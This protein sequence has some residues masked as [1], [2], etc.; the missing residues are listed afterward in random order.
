MGMELSASGSACNFDI[1][2]PQKASAKVDVVATKERTPTDMVMAVKTRNGRCMRGFG[3]MFATLTT[4]V[5]VPRQQSP[6][7]TCGAI[8]QAC[9]QQP[10]FPALQNMKDQYFILWVRSKRIK[11]WFPL[12]I[13]SGTEAAKTLKSVKENAVAKAIGGDKL[14]DFQIVKALGMSVYKQADEVKKQA[15][16]MHPK[17]NYARELQYGFKEIM[18]NT[19]FNDNP[20]PFMKIANISVI[21]PE[22]ELRNILDDAGDYA[23]EAGDKLSTVGDNVK[24]FFSGFG[25][26]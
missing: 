8:M 7:A 4:P 1:A 13:I 25:S 16:Q 9:K 11:S 19:E 21:P 5:C 15:L 26:N 14:A 18:N 2:P 23:R 10:K 24:G 3:C 12:N 20:Q 17:L 22:E 6:N